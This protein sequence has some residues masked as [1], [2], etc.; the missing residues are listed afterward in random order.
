MSAWLRNGLLVLGS[1]FAAATATAQESAADWRWF[2]VEVLVFKHA[3]SNNVESFPWHPPRQFS[4][5]HD[6]LSAYFA[7]NFVAF[8]HDLDICPS[9]EESMT[10]PVLCAESHEV[11]PFAEPW[12]NPNRIMSGYSAAPATVVDGFGG[13]MY[14]QSEPFLLAQETFEFDDFREQLERR[15]VGTTLLHVTFRTPVFNRANN[16]KIRL[17][18][19]R[20]FGQEFQSTGYEQPPFRDI[21]LTTD[22]KPTP[23]LFEELEHLLD[24]VQ[25]QQLQL[26]YQ[27]HRTPNPPPLLAARDH[28]ERSEPVW[29][30]DGQLHI[31]L[32]GNYLHI[33]SDLEL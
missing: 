2:D 8:L 9:A 20:N 18:G 29:E 7:P 21:S 17:F 32:V 12:Y 23:Q 19:G 4:G 30:L 28:D 15:N 14:S 26:S 13:D 1:V 6:P 33:G 5:H 16:H 31:Y 27:D 24:N 22:D 25:Q 10:R 3:P 11:D